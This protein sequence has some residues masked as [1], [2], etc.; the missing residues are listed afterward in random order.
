MLPEEEPP[1]PKGE[2]EKAFMQPIFMPPVIES[3]PAQPPVVVVAN[4]V[5]PQDENSAPP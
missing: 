5:D 3:E 4:N 1:T 2:H